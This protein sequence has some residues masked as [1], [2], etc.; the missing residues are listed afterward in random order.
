[1]F[2]TG[3]LLFVDLSHAE[4]RLG[5]SALAQVFGQLGKDSPDVYHA[6]DLKNAFI[7]TQEL[8]KDGSILAGKYFLIIKNL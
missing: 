6:E 3:I 7:A 4:S 1:M 8:I 2:K 5:G